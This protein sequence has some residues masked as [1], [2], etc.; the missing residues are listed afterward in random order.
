MNLQYSGN[1]VLD[2]AITLVLK[3]GGK[4]VINSVL[5]NFFPT[6]PNDY[7]LIW[8]NIK[9]R[10]EALCKDLLSDEYA[11]QL[12]LRLQGLSNDL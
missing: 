4:Q 10:V 12:E 11:Y 6:D 5:D 1:M 9:A 7:D 8:G 2:G 3:A